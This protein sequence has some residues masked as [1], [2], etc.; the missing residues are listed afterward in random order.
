MTLSVLRICSHNWTVFLISFFP[1][2]TSFGFLINLKDNKGRCLSSKLSVLKVVCPQS[3]LSSNRS[4]IALSPC[5][6][7]IMNNNK[8]CILTMTYCI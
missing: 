6:V 7:L 8:K 2:T 4:D 5:C 3:C 1:T